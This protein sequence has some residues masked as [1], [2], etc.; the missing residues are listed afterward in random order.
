MKK[1]FFYFNAISFVILIL[2]SCY[3]QHYLSK[4]IFLAN[5]NA[6]CQQW[7]P[8][9]STGTGESPEPSD[10]AEVD[11]NLP[12]PDGW[13][14]AGCQRSGGNW[15][16]ATVVSK[17]DVVT[18]TCTVSGKIKIGIVELDGSYSVGNVYQFILVTY[19]CSISPENCC[20]KQGAYIGDIK[21]G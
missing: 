13:T 21:I 8:D 1:F 7:N 15:N 4:Q 17:V 19:T 3:Y 12:G 11:D 14:K 9:D 5:V 20:I 6:L 16:M 18:K 10:T 2:F